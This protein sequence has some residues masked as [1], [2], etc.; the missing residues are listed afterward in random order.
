MSLCLTGTFKGHT[1]PQGFEINNTSVVKQAVWVVNLT[2]SAPYACTVRCRQTPHNRTSL[3][4]N[5]PYPAAAGYQLL[6]VASTI[7]QYT[8]INTIHP[9]ENTCQQPPA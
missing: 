8:P 4:H 6:A 2:L 9:A 7:A 5:Q 3:R 1:W